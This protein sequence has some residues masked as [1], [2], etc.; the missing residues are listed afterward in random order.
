MLIFRLSRCRLVFIIHHFVRIN[1]LIIIAF[2]VNTKKSQHQTVL[3]QC[4]TAYLKWVY[5]VLVLLGTGART[6]RLTATR[7]VP[8]YGRYQSV[9]TRLGTFLLIAGGR[10]RS[11]KIR[12]NF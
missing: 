2:L 11:G 10:Y 12:V 6:G 4:L 1:L 8:L 5:P 3:I 7:T 9:W